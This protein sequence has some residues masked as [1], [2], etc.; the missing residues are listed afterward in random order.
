MEVRLK[1][2]HCSKYYFHSF[3]FSFFNSKNWKKLSSLATA[4]FDKTHGLLIGDKTGEI[5]FLNV[6][7]ISKLSN[8]II[9]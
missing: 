4:G 9:E 1:L 8:E 3:K 5:K 6:K 7:N 2:L